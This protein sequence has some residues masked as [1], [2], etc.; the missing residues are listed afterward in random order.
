MYAEK[1]ALVLLTGR[2][3]SLREGFSDYHVDYLAYIWP[4]GHL[5][6]APPIYVS[7]MMIRRIISMGLINPEEEDFALTA[8]RALPLGAGQMSAAFMPPET[9]LLYARELLAEGAVV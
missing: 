1:S 3:I 2:K 4:F 8:L 6:S 5:P 7:N 9:A